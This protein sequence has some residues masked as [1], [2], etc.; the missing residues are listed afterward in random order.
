MFK[1]L[2]I[3]LGVTFA[4]AGSA[5]AAL[6]SYD[7][8]WIGANNYTLSG[9]FTFD[10]A[11]AGASVDQTELT[12]F[13]IEGFLNGTSL[14]TYR[15]P[16]YNFSFDAVTERLGGGFGGVS[17][18][19]NGQIWNVPVGRRT[20]GIGLDSGIHSQGLYLNG[21]RYRDSILGLEQ[22]GSGLTATLTPSA[23]PLPAAAWMFIAG[24]TALFGGKWRLKRKALAAA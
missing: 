2:L 1:K 3:A 18:E 20:A 22:N 21:I 14:G 4:M 23:V 24:L 19:S 7:I 5:N 17:N 16:V 12:Y 11:T 10:D 9:Q 15:G 13:F 6:K 8:S